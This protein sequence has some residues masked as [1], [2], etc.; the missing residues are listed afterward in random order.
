MTKLHQQKSEKHTMIDND[1]DNRIVTA[2]ARTFPLVDLPAHS[3]P[4]FSDRDSQLEIDALT[5][6][7]DLARMSRERY[8]KSPSIPNGAKMAKDRNELVARLKRATDSLC[9]RYPSATREDVW[10][11][12]LKRFPSLKYVFQGG[13]PND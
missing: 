4:L 9:G 1:T 3:E 10:M 8:D 11:E 13:M 12:I 5:P 7:V 2:E 6:Y